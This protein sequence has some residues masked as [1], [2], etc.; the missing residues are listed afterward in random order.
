MMDAAPDFAQAVLAQAFAA[1]AARWAR[2]HGASVQDTEAV[3]HAAAALSL[4]TSA[5]HVCVRLTDLAPCPQAVGKPGE[6]PPGSKAG[7]DPVDLPSFA[8]GSGGPADPAAWRALL[9]SSGVVGTSAAPGAMPLVL[10]SDDRLY[11]HRYFDYERRL[12]TR[13]MRARAATRDLGGAT[14]RLRGRLSALFAGNADRLGT[15][16]DWQKLATALA[17]RGSLVIISGGPGTGKTTTVVNLLACLIELDPACRIAL[18]APTGKAAARMTE[19]IRQRAA[20]LPEAIRARLPTESFTAHRLLGVTPGAGGFVHHA[21]NPLAIDALVVDEASMLDLALAT[22]LLEA[23]PDTARIVLLGDKDQLSAVESGSV[24]AELGTD[25]TLTAPCIRELALLTG[26][27]AEQIRAP[28]PSVPGVLQDAVVWFTHNFRFARDSGIGHL[29]ALVNAGDAAQALDWL[30]SDSDPTVQWI[31]DGAPLPAARTLEYMRDGYAP[32]LQA[33]RDDPA[34]HAAVSAAFAQFR[35][36]CAVREG[37]R[38]VAA[39]NAEFT[40][41]WLSALHGA[42]QAPASDWFVGRPVL[43]LRNDYVQKLFNG[44]VGIA[45]PDETGQLMVYFSQPDGG[46][47]AIAPVRLPQHETA[48]AMTVHKAQGSEF[49]RVMVVLPAQRSRVLTRELLYTGLTRARSRVT[50]CA[51]AA[52]LGAAIGTTTQR[53]SGLLARLRECAS[54][55]GSGTRASTGE[56]TNASAPAAP[57]ATEPPT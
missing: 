1:H 2:A 7:R 43:V 53:H 48:F 28:T 38:G 27:P 32:L 49:D 31:D 40:R 10:D 41:S 3:R 44:D 54:A 19:A 33:V 50:L 57:P 56:S 4:A 25:P 11:L 55:P 52:V 26:T 6:L 8:R 21:G 37:P 13:L 24:F 15:Q 51:S 16:A 30:R 22:R 47:R 36:L 9:L 5:G 29:A 34:D 46:F 23:V 12:A 42:Q 17:L 45:L 14:E 18:A 35:V 39:L 20:G